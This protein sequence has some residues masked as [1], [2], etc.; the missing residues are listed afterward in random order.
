MTD[1]EKEEFSLHVRLPNADYYEKSNVS[2]NSRIDKLKAFVFKN[3]PSLEG[4]NLKEYF[5]TLPVA[6]PTPEEILAVE[7]TKIYQFHDFEKKIL[8]HETIK[9]RLV[10]RSLLNLHL[11][12]SLGQYIDEKS[13]SHSSSAPPI[14][15]DVVAVPKPKKP[16]SKA[17]KAPKKQTLNGDQQKE[18]KTY[19]SSIDSCY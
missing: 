15:S 11:P 1:I 4:Q 7:F 10:H 6:Q 12:N 8:A 2:A 19:F 18:K 14:R 9:I 5:F 16:T 13:S 17:A 3:V